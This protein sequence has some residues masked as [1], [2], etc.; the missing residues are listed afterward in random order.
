MGPERVS[1]DHTP[2]SAAHQREKDAFKSKKGILSLNPAVR[3][4]PFLHRS[5]IALCSRSRNPAGIS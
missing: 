2:G 5:M 3:Q 4:Q 1:N